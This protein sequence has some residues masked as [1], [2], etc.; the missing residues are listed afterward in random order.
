MTLSRRSFVQKG[1][2]SAAL[3]ASPLP[4]FLPAAVAAAPAKPA[5]HTPFK[6][7][8]STYSYWH[9]KTPKYPIEKV[10]D[11][12]MALSV[13]GVDI[14]HR[15]MESEDNAYLQKLK[16]HAFLHGVDLISLSIHQDFVSPDA[17]ERQKDIDHTLRC[18]EL[19][20]KMG[21]P[22]IR[23][24][25]GRWGTIKSFDELMA[26]RGVEPAIPG[27]TE[28]DAFKWCIDC[29]EKC[30]PKAQECGV[31]LTLENHWGLT[32]TP[33]GLLRIRQAIDSPW[34]GVLMD[35][36]NFLEHPYD[37]LEKVVPYASFVQ[38]KTYYGG[39][40]WYTLDLD[41]KRIV[42]ILRRANYKGYIAIEFEGKEAPE[43]GV[44]KSVAML[45]E[46]MA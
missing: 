43:S 30:L 31:L 35:T 34:L 28:D 4:A 24:N 45:R 41:Y 13:E 17:A 32:S 46:A 38:A 25:S 33:E 11:E 40:E 2:A 5:E 21:I 20:Y 22:A 14:L 42:G 10:I 7:A 9:F 15:Q 39:G 27:Y 19:A 1:L 37:K 44:R 6:L 3:L 12:A 8:L 23:L 29:I 26:K 18:I 36:G 16:R